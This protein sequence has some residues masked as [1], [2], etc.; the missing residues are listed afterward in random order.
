M[1]SAMA[2]ETKKGGSSRPREMVGTASWYS[3]VVASRMASSERK[4]VVAKTRRVMASRWRGTEALGLGD[5]RRKAKA[6]VAVLTSQQ[7]DHPT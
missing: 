7:M 3:A 1:R 5:G 6:N 2:K 4:M